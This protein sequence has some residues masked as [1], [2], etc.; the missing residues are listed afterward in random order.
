MK[1]EKALL[2][3]TV[4]ESSDFNKLGLTTYVKLSPEYVILSGEGRR[5]ICHRRGSH[6]YIVLGIYEKKDPQIDLDRIRI[7]A[8]T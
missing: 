6:E 8:R 1:H 7:G 5:F 4:L 2:E 3:R